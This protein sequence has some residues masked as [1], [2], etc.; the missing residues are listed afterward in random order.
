MSDGVA[1]FEDKRSQFRVATGVVQGFHGKLRKRNAPAPSAVPV[2]PASGA[3]CKG[4]GLGTGRRDPRLLLD[5]PLPAIFLRPSSVGSF[6]CPANEISSPK[7]RQ[8][9][10]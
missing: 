6:P 1:R 7:N 5:S 9:P 3:A 8:W 2:R 4:S 10:R